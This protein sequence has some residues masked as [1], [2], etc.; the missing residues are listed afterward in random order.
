M[1]FELDEQ[2][3]M[4]GD[5]ATQFAKAEIASRAK[6]IDKKAE[7]PLDIIKKMGGI[8]LL[9]IP[10]SSEYGGSGAG[11]LGYVVHYPDRIKPAF[12]DFKKVV[13]QPDR[14]Q[15]SDKTYQKVFQTCLEFMNPC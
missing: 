11:E 4:I 12:F 10:V 7:F 9:G 14:T 8:G 1:S 15:I 13:Y 3:K 2:Y 5:I 6:E